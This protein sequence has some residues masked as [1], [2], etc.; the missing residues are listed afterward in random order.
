[1]HRSAAP[2]RSVNASAPADTRIY[3]V[4]DIHG[5]ADLLSEITAR[6]D[7]DIQRRPIARTVEVY[8]GD[9]IDR[10]PHSRTVIDLLAVR[11]VANRAVCLRGNH[12][13]VMEGFLQ[14]P[15]ILKYW[16]PLGGMQ[17]L[18][19]YGIELR[20][21]TETAL[22]LH[23][24]FLD[25]F[26]RAHELFMQCLCNQFS[27]GDFSFVH[28]GIR[29]GIPIAQQDVNDLIWIRNEF[30]ES[31]R[32][33]ERFIVHGHTPV[34]HPDIRHNRINIDTCAWRTGTLTCIAI[35]GSAILFL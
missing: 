32:D 10:G 4:G 3:A 7:D 29:P 9:Y 5:R 19:S 13:A 11:L 20:D 26:P 34:P 8:L 28:A 33:H 27:C 22:D 18:A 23:R 24:R 30:L 25:A 2:S 16:Q 31:T 14:D 15:A 21:E 1:M 35:E 6:I 17:T 12:E